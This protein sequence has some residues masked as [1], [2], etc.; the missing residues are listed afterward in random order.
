MVNTSCSCHFCYKS[1]NAFKARGK[2]DS[3]S[4]AR[5]Y[6]VPFYYK[7][8]K[9]G[10]LLLRKTCKGKG[11]LNISMSLESVRGKLG[12]STGQYSLLSAKH[13]NL[14]PLTSHKLL[15]GPDDLFAQALSVL[16]VLLVSTERSL[17][18]HIASSLHSSYKLGKK[19][20]TS[21]KCI[22]LTVI[23]FVC[24]ASDPGH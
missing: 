16:I 5:K 18:F 10:V 20:M 4:S 11:N 15:L 1:V 9:Q 12:Q 19:L 7:Q 23:D 21:Y 22:K 24:L 6:Y 8:G 2:P 3:F 14:L 17:I 13:A